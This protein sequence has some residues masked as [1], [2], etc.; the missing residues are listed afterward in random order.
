[1][2]FRAA[3]GDERVISHLYIPKEGT[4]PYQ[5][6]FFVPAASMFTVRSVDALSDPFEFLVRSGRAVMITALKGTL[7]REP[8]GLGLLGPNDLRDR[9]LQMSKDVQRSIDYL[10]TRPKDIDMGKLAYYGLSAGGAL[11]PLWLAVEK[12]I[13]TAV[14]VSTG[15]HPFSTPAAVDPWNYV[16]RVKI[17][18]LMLNGRDDF[19]FPLETNQKPFFEA[20][21]SAPTEKR[22][23]LFDGGHVNVTTRPDVI[24]EFLDWLDRY[25]GLT[26]RTE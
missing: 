7:E 11:S 15:I 4:P 8:S 12:R 23:R 20:L 24:K 13:K 18:V 16:P 5:I 14:L 6:V 22:H 10:E 2:S 1:M 25:L 9:L 26:E 3:Y 19:S 17:P 21:G